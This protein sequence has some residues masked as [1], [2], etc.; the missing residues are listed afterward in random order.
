M[1]IEG[2]L[3]AVAEIK[4]SNLTLKRYYYFQLT[5]VVA[6]IPVSRIPIIAGLSAV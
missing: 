3:E 1:G 6:A 5:D 2:E 4:V